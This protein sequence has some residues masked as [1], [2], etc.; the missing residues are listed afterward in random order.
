VD[1]KSLENAQNE[2][3]EIELVYP[4]AKEVKGL[5]NK[6]SFDKAEILTALALLEF[7]PGL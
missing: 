5:I 4:D 3:L 2:L 7:K 6:Q 1:D